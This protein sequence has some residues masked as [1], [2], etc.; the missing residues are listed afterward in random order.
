MEPERPLAG[1]TIVVTRPAGQAG[2]LAER[3]RAAGGEPILFPVLEIVDVEDLRPFYAL[4][5]R[6]DEFD[7]AVFV[8]PSAVTKALNLIRARRP[9][10]PRLR[11]AAVGRGSV[12]ALA[13]FGVGEVIAPR[14]SFDSES[15]LAQPEMHAVAGQRIVIFRGEGGRDL[16]GD[17]LIR[18]GARLEYA[19]CYRRGRPHADSAPLMNAWGG[20]GVD[21]IIVTSS[22]GVRNLYEMVGKLG[23]PRLRKTLVVLPHER[24]AQTARTLGMSNILL[25]GTGDDALVTA[26]IDR[27]TVARARGT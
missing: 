23:Q 11:Y 19:E 27:F 2:L 5:D 26:L 4:A 17:T 9:L 18:R 8:S 10:P 24:I 13:Q 1:R 12:R 6:L 16:L 3:I 7:L 15:L 25:T 21:A 22:E 20:H 14:E